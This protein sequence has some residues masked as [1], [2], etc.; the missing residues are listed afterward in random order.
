MLIAAIII[1]IIGVVASGFDPLW[2]IDLLGGKAGPLGVILVI[3]WIV[4][5]IAG[6][7]SA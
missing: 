6:I 3:G 1:Y 2:P 4:L 7:A 5:L